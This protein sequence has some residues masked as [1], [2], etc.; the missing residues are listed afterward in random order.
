MKAETPKQS[1]L[2]RQKILLGRGD[3]IPLDCI[4]L[5]RPFFFFLIVKQRLKISR[6]AH[7]SWGILE[8][9]LSSRSQRLSQTMVKER[10][11]I[12]VCSQFV[13]SRHAKRGTVATPSWPV[14]HTFARA[15][16]IL[17]HFQTWYGM[18]GRRKEGEKRAERKTR[19]HFQRLG[20][21]PY[22]C[23]VSGWYGTLKRFNSQQDIEKL[24]IYSQNPNIQ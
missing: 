18:N 11:M 24:T 14:P 1:Q 7:I 23:V 6:K 10:E 2:M 3:L 5:N 12:Q 19:W 4:Q 16:D 21:D 15:T 13:R 22:P 17:F 20:K 8:I 9:R